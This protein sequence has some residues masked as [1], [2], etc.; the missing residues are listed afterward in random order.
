[1]KCLAKFLCVCVLS[2]GCQKAFADNVPVVHGFQDVEK[3]YA[4]LKKLEGF[5][6]RSLGPNRLHSPI[7]HNAPTQAQVDILSKKLDDISGEVPTLLNRL[8]QA[9]HT[10]RQLEEKLASLVQRRKPEA[11]PADS[12]LEMPMAQEAML[13]EESTPLMNAGNDMDLG[14]NLG[15]PATSQTPELSTEE[16]EKKARTALLTGQYDVAE[17][18][19]EALLERELGGEQA[20]S[21]H[22]YLG[23]IAHV[24]KNHAKA[25][26]HYLKAFQSAPNSSKAPKS[27]LK[28]SM[29]LHDLDKKKACCA[30]LSKLLTEYPKADSATRTMAEAKKKEYQCAP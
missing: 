5:V 11:Q 22:F 25:S 27:L 10:I 1:M 9:E 7:T 4:D 21:A 16:L 15:I 19:F 30:S 6:Y 28:L 26:E 17:Q 29:K 14:L 13:Q 12:P 23:E 20:A 2:L 3:I 8:E 18:S 24:K